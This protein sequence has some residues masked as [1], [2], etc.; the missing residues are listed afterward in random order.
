MKQ[1]VKCQTLEQGHKL[2]VNIIILHHVSKIA[3]NPF[4]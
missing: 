4:M 1:E 3:F 2:G